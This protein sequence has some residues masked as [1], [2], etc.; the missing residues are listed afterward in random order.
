MFY[1]FKNTRYFL[2][3]HQLF[4]RPP[5]IQNMDFDTV[6]EKRHSVRSFK[7]KKA[8]WK[9]ALE[10][11]DAANQG[12][13]ADN[14]NPLKF[15]IIE[16]EK[17]IDKIAELAGQ[18]WM[19]ESS[20]LIFV[21]SDDTNLENLHGERGKKYARQQA[22]AA[23]NTLILKLTDLGLSSCW[24]GAFTDEQIK[25]H[26][27]IPSHIELEAIIPIGYEKTKPAPRRRKKA[28][29]HSLNWESWGASKRPSLFA[30]DAPE[31]AFIE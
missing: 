8:S 28:L 30:E 25:Q 9:F 29:E 6:I 19:N 2:G 1:E 20:M 12:A 27:K 23:I 14:R 31:P 18:L 3:N 17:T 4:K 13:F 7:N 5:P 15:I 16:E 26:L 21:C 10:A 11:I 24:V 22:G